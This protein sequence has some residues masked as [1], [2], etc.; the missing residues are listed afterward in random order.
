MPQ[1]V[2]EESFW[3]GMGREGGEMSFQRTEG[4]NGEHARPDRRECGHGDFF[5]SENNFPWLAL[6]RNS[7][8]RTNNP[9]TAS[10]RD[11]SQWKGMSTPY[12]IEEN[13]E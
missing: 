12:T 11:R 10:A 9:P 3:P 7:F 8:A 13:H 4:G 5:K 6:M 2:N 1:T